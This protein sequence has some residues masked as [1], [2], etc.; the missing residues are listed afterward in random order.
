MI[1]ELLPTLTP[2]IAAF[3][4]DIH[5]H[6]GTGLRRDSA[7]RPR[8]PIIL[9]GLGLEVHRGIARTGIVAKL[10]LGSSPRAI[11][12]RADMDALPLTN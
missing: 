5:A 2:K 10:A 9:D 4:R 3:R 1:N 11:G 6:P 12:L 8:W 7:P